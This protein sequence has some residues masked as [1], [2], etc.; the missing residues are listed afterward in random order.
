MASRDPGA[1]LRFGGVY[2]FS[3]RGLECAGILGALVLWE[4][5]PRLHWLDSQF[6]PPPSV[7]LADGYRLLVTGA[8]GVHVAVSLARTLVGLGFAMVTAMPL[9]LLVGGVF[10]RSYRFV[11]A[12]FR[13]LGQVN[14]FSL[15]PLF[16]LLFGI[17]ELAK[18]C[19]LWWTC[20]WPLLFGTLSGL[21]SVDPSLVRVAR[22]MSCNRWMLLFKLMIPAALPVVMTGVRLGASVAFVMLIAAEMIG[23]ST[24]LGWLVLNSQTNYI[25]PRL[26]FAAAFIAG[27]G[28]GMDRLLLA[29][30]RRIVGWKP[31]HLAR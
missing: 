30:E 25:I 18:I 27:L 10:P 31:P 23:A 16:V 1:T 22:S 11:G 26:Y 14:A 17:G 8:L 20:F 28:V 3:D 21:Q 12:L 13:L 7:V 15:F 4:A 5:A 6:F 9:G 24:G 29:A 19:I 2:V